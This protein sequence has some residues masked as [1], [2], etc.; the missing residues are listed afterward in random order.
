M[1]SQKVIAIAQE[2]GYKFF[3]NGF[4]YRKLAEIT[5][6]E[7]N[8]IS[9]TSNTSKAALQAINALINQKR[10]AAKTDEAIATEAEQASQE[11]QPVAAP[12]VERR[13]YERPSYMGVGV[14]VYCG[15]ERYGYAL[16]ELLDRP[17]EVDYTLERQRM[18][19]RDCDRVMTFP[20]YTYDLMRY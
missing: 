15:D 19:D 5:D 14:E 13:F 12:V 18:M 11:L 7:G 9:W 2:K 1:I 4:G 10:L 8:H 16:A 20:V 3:V 6:L 17:V